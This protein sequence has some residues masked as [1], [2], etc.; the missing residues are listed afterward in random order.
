MKC[1]YKKMIKYI[2]LDLNKNMQEVIDFS[3]G[4]PTDLYNYTKRGVMIDSVDGRVEV[5]HGDLL[6]Y[7]FGIRTMTP[8]DFYENFEI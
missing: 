3:G 5:K 8:S 1:K 2:Q 6:V 7:L 4:D